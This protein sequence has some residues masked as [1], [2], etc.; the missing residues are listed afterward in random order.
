M[1]LIEGAIDPKGEKGEVIKLTNTMIRN[2]VLDPAAAKLDRKPKKL[3][4][5]DHMLEAKIRCG[6]VGLLEM[7]RKTPT[8][9][10]IRIS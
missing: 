5:I 1:E 8:D 10:T 7:G 6:L 2:T 9:G 3:P 4:V